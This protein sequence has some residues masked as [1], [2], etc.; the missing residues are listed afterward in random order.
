MQKVLSL[1][2]ESTLN[3]CLSGLDQ[4]A[5]DDEYEDDGGSHLYQS[6]HFAKTMEFYHE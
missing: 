4:L 2:N 1:V 6:G 5:T 3:G